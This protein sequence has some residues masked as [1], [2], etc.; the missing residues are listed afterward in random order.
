MARTCARTRTHA[1]VREN[2]VK[3]KPKYMLK[4]T[5]NAQIWHISAWVRPRYGNGT[6]GLESAVMS[7]KCVK[8]FNINLC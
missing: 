3:E 1:R 4:K 5:K 6:H 8:G 2:Y 7:S